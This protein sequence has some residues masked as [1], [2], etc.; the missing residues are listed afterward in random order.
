VRCNFDCNYWGRSPLLWHPAQKQ[1]VPLRVRGLRP[2][3]RPLGST[4][5][6]HLFSGPRFR[7]QKSWP[8]FVTGPGFGSHHRNPGQSCHTPHSDVTF[9]RMPGVTQNDQKYGPPGFCVAPPAPP[10]PFAGGPV[11]GN[12]FPDQKFRSSLITRARGSTRT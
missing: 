7:T 5:P 9:F 2:T 3:K 6:D 11:S 1:L 12:Y 4:C 10:G 8:S